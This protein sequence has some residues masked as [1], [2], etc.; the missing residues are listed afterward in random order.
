MAKGNYK[1]IK[2]KIAGFFGRNLL[3]STIMIALVVGTIST[4]LIITKS[5]KLKNSQADSVAQGTAGWFNEQIGRVK[6]IAETLSHE[7]YIGV[8]YAESEAYLAKCITENS[9][10]YAYYFGLADDRCVFSDGWEVPEDYK[11]TERDWYPDAIANPDDISVSSAYVDADTGRIVVTVSKAIIKDGSPVGVFAA[12]FFVDDLIDMAESLSS[13]SS[14]AILVDKDGTVLTHKNKKYTPLADAEGEMIATGYK[15]IKIPEKLIKPQGRTNAFSKY[16]YV[17][18]YIENAGITVIF[19]T[20][21]FSFYGGLLSFYLI[22]VILIVII[23]FI[24]TASVRKVLSDSLE[25]L[26]ELSQVSDDMKNGKLD[27][28]TSNT[29]GDEVGTLCVAIEQSNRAIRGYIRDISEKLEDMSNGDLTVEVTDEY[30]GD[31]APLKD[32]INNIV[33]SMKNAITIISDASQAVHSSAQN[34][35]GGANSLAGDVESVMEIV[36]DVEE[37]I[38][39]I[40]KSFKKNMDIVNEAGALSDNAKKYLDEGNS[41]LAELVEAMDEITD[42]SNRIS[43]VIDIINEIAAQTNLLALNASIEA[44]R[45]GEAGKGFAVVADSVRTLAEQTAAAVSNTTSLIAES[46]AAVRKGN[47]LVVGTSE[48]MTQI[49]S[50][51][52]DVN[53]KIQGISDCIEEENNTIR[54][55][56]DAVNNMETF[57]TNTQATSEECVALSEVLN[58][59]AD[60]MQNAVN[61]FRI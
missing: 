26:E 35:Q 31:F 1:S 50:I 3:I 4:A 20:S 9:A 32:S 11:A 51:T 37:K 38:D 28:E 5:N 48:K 47:E 18:E 7:D 40:Q 34:V 17:S 2:A 44:A 12:D 22:C 25:P 43:A 16:F 52:N 30:A 57:T 23:Y 54:D 13:S 39:I 8:R 60:N 42:K 55:V 6:I 61:R 15:D 36:S 33:A 24:T 56:K 27:Y 14:F 45:A 19:A 49:V 41:A 59:Q 53:E 10:A 46:E 58:E 29:T 21:F